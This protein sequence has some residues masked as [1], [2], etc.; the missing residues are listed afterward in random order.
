MSR[1]KSRLLPNAFA[2]WGA[3]VFVAAVSFVLAPVVVN[4]LGTTAYGIWSLLVATVGYLGLLDFG[5]RGAVTRYVAQ[6]LAVADDES[7]ARVAGAAMLLFVLLGVIAMVFALLVAGFA[8]RW[9]D[10]PAG[11]LGDAR[12][13]LGIA[14]LTVATTLVGA[15]YGGIVTGLERFDLSSA[16]E[17]VITTVRSVAIYALLKAG[18]GIVSLALIYLASAILYG[19]LMR[20]IVAR[21]LPRLRLVWTTSAR[22]SMRELLTFSM[23][24]SAIHALGVIIF[25]TDSFVIASALPVG[26]VGVYAIAGNLM[27]QTRKVVSAL[28]KMFTPR[29]SAMYAVGDPGIVNAILDGAR[30]ASLVALP[31]AAVLLLRGESFVSL[32]IG[33]EYGPQTGAVIRCFS[34]VLWVGAARAIA[35]AAIIGAGMPGR[36]ITMFAFEAVANLALSVVLVG[37]LG[38]VG[39]AIGTLVPALIVSV[40]LVPKNL[41]R[42]LDVPVSD[43]LMQALLLPSVAVLPYAGVTAI[44]EYLWP[45]SGLL[46]FIL[47]TAATLPIALAGALLVSLNAAERGFVLRRLSLRRS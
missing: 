25:Y 3:L 5:I 20:M 40:A 23:R 8:G 35:G 29:V 15:V 44:L 33:P 9:F 39:V 18:Y 21:L 47:Q 34:M 46:V 19:I 28:S 10:I 13:A 4:S 32:W 31:M 37:R 41:H 42:C 12:L 16:V 2:N 22:E 36:L 14:G 45:A 26:A 7:V 6:H 43:Y 38:L 30:Y 27:D 1:S 17:I 24:L 11:L